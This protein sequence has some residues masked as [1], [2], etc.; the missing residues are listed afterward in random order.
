M[1]P[2][3][4]RL[5]L[6]RALASPPSAAAIGR[7]TPSHAFIGPVCA[8]ALVVV[9]GC[10]ST[11]GGGTPDAST[12]FDGSV[13]QDGALGPGSSS[14]TGSNSGSGSGSGSSGVGSSSG[15]GSG[16]GSSGVGS[17]SGIG[18]DGGP[19]GF[20]VVTNRYDNA[21]TGS[22][23]SET[24][25]N[26]ANVGGGKFG[27]QGSHAVD[28]HILAQPLYMTGLSI[29][30]ATHNVVFVATEHDTVYAFD[31]DN[32]TTPALWTSSLGTPM[33]AT[34][35]TNGWLKP[36]SPGSTVTCADMF[37]KA[38][39]TSTPVIDPGTGRMYVV[40][41]NL[42]NGA[43]FH[44]LHV[45]DVLTGMD[46]AG[47]PVTIAG[48]VAG[49]GISNDGGSIAFESPHALNRP[50]LLLAGGNVYIAFGSHC[51]DP[52]YHG[53]VFSYSAA[54][55]MQTGIFN[56]T[57][58][59][60]EGAIWQ[61]GMGLPA[62]DQN[63]VYFA[64]G[65]GDVDPSNM[66]TMLGQSIGRLQLQ[67]TGLKM[68]DWWTM[69]DAVPRNASDID[70]QSGVMVLPNPKVLIGGGKDGR[71]Y[72]LDPANLGKYVPGTSYANIL[73]GTAPFGTHIHV[74][75]YWNGPSGPTL[76]VWTENG[77]PL[78]AL[79]FNGMTLNTTP[80]MTYAGSATHP[81]GILSLSSNG[82]MMG[83]GVLWATFTSATIDT[84]NG[85]DAW[86]HLVPGA[87]YAFDANN[88]TMPIWTS[89]ANKARDDLGILAKFNAPMV[90]NGRVYVGTNGT[91]DGG[92]LQVYGLLP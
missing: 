79:R 87:M 76:Y 2:S 48:S 40:A 68:T 74:P 46:V 75:V 28:G 39:I 62:D 19:I 25:L 73:Q 37:P 33:D 3:N 6:F 30:G 35:S 91:P 84:V 57:P 45:L 88:L 59:G 1:T 63:N 31:A 58:N 56:V 11:P 7:P 55:L 49:T 82:S 77:S 18:P 64:A 5:T 38:G 42:E 36:Y 80:V 70:L 90:A 34:V 92:K 44:R 61:S 67:A 60:A 65:N 9:L 52:P 20:A 86:H 43:Y 41:K 47:S 29:G 21:R 53:W 72:V 78:R 23:T 14:G 85:G 24:I 17:S 8:C 69:P 13:G 32:A 4:I 26:V 81:G 22:N 83:T 15:T 10:G 51:D 16:S 71:I 27:L 50:G 89:L 54:T 12:A 66:G